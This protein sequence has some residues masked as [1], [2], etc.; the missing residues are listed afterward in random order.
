[1]T[2]FQPG[3]FLLW[4]AAL[5]FAAG[6]A[7]AETPERPKHL[8]LC[9]DE[10]ETMP[11]S[12]P[13]HRGLNFLFTDAAAAELGFKVDYIARPWKRCARDVETGKVDGV[14]GVS[15]R[16]ERLEI[17]AFPLTA[18][19]K[20]DNSRALFSSG[21]SLYKLKSDPLE[22]DGGAFKNLT[23]KIVVTLGHTSAERLR[24]I[25]APVEEVTAN[26]PAI[27]AMVAAGHCQAAVIDS[28][29]GDSLIAGNPSYEAKLEKMP[30]PLQEAHP[31]FIVL[32]RQ[33]A[34][35]YQVF[36]ESFW[37]LIR[38]MRGTPHFQQEIRALLGQ[39]R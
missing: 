8:L 17:A 4:F 29:V 12:G 33:F 3:F 23:G 26:S 20:I 31:E 9:Y 7:H 24:A 6:L 32:S 39:T 2:S 30:V 19:G 36:A 37:D 34:A 35:R 21:N 1:M 22:W 10:S 25:G 28:A 14:I 15:F 16:P 27:L 5:W 38:T 11:F 18:D 13:H